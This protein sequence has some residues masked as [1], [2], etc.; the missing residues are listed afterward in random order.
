MTITAL[1][2]ALVIGAPPLVVTTTQDLASIAEVIA[3][4]RLRIEYLVP[5]V[6]NTHDVELKPSYAL[7]LA[8]A[9]A[10]VR[11]GLGLDDWVLTLIETARN[12]R[13][14]PG[15]PGNADASEGCSLLD[16]P[17][18]AVDRSMGDVHPHGNPHYL[19]DPENG[20][21]VARNLSRRFGMLW[22]EHRA[23]FD[24]G[25][26]RFERDHARH[27]ER[28]SPLLDRIRG[29]KVVSYHRMWVY[30]ARF[31]GI[32]P[33]GELEPKPGIPP[34]AGHTRALIERM[35]AEGARVI[36]REPFYEMRTPQ[37]VAGKTGA[38]VV[39]LAPQVG[40]LP[41]ADSYWAMFETNLRMLVEA[42]GD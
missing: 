34:T 21:I 27:R 30:F 7:K 19:L 28:W 33:V 8:R 38:R 2:A 25:L 35:R 37:F 5:G 20:L 13:L 32:E 18:G 29:T 14:R 10:V 9:D 23:A 41:D 12:P 4:D 42:L 3:G 11:V 36:I 26:A 31:S 15:T 17:A 22:P 1:L 40:A 24:S 6:A 16:V 39:T